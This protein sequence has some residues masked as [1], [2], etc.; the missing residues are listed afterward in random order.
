MRDQIAACM[1]QIWW[2]RS[3]DVVRAAY[4]TLSVFLIK[5]WKG[6]WWGLEEEEGRGC[7][8]S[9]RMDGRR[10]EEGTK[11][12]ETVEKERKS[13]SWCDDVIKEE[14]VLLISKGSSWS[15]TGGQHYTSVTHCFM[16]T[17]KPRAMTTSARQQE[18]MIPPLPFLH[19]HIQYIHTHTLSL[20]V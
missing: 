4:W 19:T 12:W 9:K 2:N 16:K 1:L 20:L 8:W 11:W 17:K 14:C 5:S 18:L 13:L 15:C 7:D 3:E 10:T 6:C